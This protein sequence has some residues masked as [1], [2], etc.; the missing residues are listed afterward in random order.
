VFLHG[1]LCSEKTERRLGYFRRIAG[2]TTGAL[3]GAHYLETGELVS[4]GAELCRWVRTEDHGCMEYEISVLLHLSKP[5]NR[6]KQCNII[7]MLPR[8]K[9]K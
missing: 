4:P 6:I 1:L 3:E 8:I 5:K 2:N 7:K 9:Q